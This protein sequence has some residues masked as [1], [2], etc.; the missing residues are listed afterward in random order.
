[1]VLLKQEQPGNT[2]CTVTISRAV[3]RQYLGNYDFFWAPIL[4]RH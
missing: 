2:K 3:A 4:K 1:M